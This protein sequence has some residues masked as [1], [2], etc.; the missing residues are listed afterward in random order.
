MK[1]IVNGEQKYYFQTNLMLL[2]ED[3]F[4]D[5]KVQQIRSANGVQRGLLLKHEK[6]RR[7]LLAT[8]F[9]HF[10]G[11]I[12]GK[13]PLRFAYD[14][15]LIGGSCPYESE[16]TLDEISAVQGV[17]GA[18]IICLEAPDEEESFFPTKAGDLLLVA[19][20]KP[21]PF[22]ELKSGRYLMM[23]YA[24]KNAVYIR[25]DQDPHLHFFRERG[26]A[27]GDQ[28]QD[29]ESPLLCMRNHV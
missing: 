2:L 23:V 15:L 22:H 16:V 12:L 27:Y 26:Y 13:K 3:V 19:Y 24:E 7:L 25:N 5:D 6:L 1:F 21:I 28:L 9:S 10:V 4:N 14:Q 18:T 11:E 20:D 17:L 8:H 29:P